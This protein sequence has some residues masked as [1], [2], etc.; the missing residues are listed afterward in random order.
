MRQQDPFEQLGAGIVGF[1][2]HHLILTQTGG[3]VTAAAEGGGLCAI[4]HSSK[5]ISIFRSFAGCDRGHLS[6]FWASRALFDEIGTLPQAEIRATAPLS[7][8]AAGNLGMP[9]RFQAG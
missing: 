3:F 9:R 5:R 7:F 8:D 2:A 6:E 4:P 1:R